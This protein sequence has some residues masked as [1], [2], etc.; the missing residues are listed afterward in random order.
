MDKLRRHRGAHRGC[1]TR[2]LSEASEIL[3]QD[4]L[5]SSADLQERIDGLRDKDTALAELDKQI[6]D[7][8]DGEEFDADIVGALD[9]HESIVKADLQASICDERACTGRFYR[10]RNQPAEAYGETVKEPQGCGHRDT[11]SSTV[12][13]STDNTVILA[14]CPFKEWTDDVP[15]SVASQDTPRVIAGSRY[16]QRKSANVF[17]ATAAASSAGSKGTL[18]AIAEPQPGLSAT[19]ARDVISLLYARSG[20]NEELTVHS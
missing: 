8:L 18:L 1:T 15:P 14:R 20:A 11:A 13:P 16:Q 6:A 19:D 10:Q 2:L 3:L 12:C 5:P 17:P 7:A 9:Y 4:T